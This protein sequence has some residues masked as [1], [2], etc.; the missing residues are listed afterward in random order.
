MQRPSAA[1]HRSGPSTPARWTASRKSSSGRAEAQLR[2]R[3]QSSGT[4]HAG[5]CSAAVGGQQLS[6]VPFAEDQQPVGELG[7]DGEHEPLG[8][9]VRLW[10]TRWDLQHGDAGVG[11][12]GVEGGGEKAAV[13]WPVRSRIRYVNTAARSP[14]STSRWSCGVTRNRFQSWARDNPAFDFQWINHGFWHVEWGGAGPG[15]EVVAG[16]KPWHQ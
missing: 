7:A 11:E 14:S 9:G 4:P 5:R 3:V 6:Q 1:P 12:H 10:T 8:V 16:P 15:R 13:N 2:P